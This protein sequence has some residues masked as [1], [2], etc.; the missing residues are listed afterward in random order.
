[1]Q[2]Q[3]DS[4]S[5]II[6]QRFKKNRFAL[7]GLVIAF[8]AAFVCVFSYLIIPDSS[9]NANQMC[10]QASL[11]PPGSK[12][13]YLKVKSELTSESSGI[14]KLFFG[15]DETN[16][17][18]PVVDYQLT[19]NIIHYKELGSEAFGW[20]TISALKVVNNG[21]DHSYLF[22][23]KYLLGADKFGRDVFSR[24][25]L[26][27]RVSF[28][29]GFIAVFISLFIGIVLGSLAGYYR[30]IIDSLITWMVNVI[31]SIPTLL[32]VVAITLALG[33]GFVQVFVAVGLT[34]WVEVAR[35]VRGQFFT[36][37]EAQF[38]EAGKSFGFNNARIIFKHILPNVLG[39]VIVIA[40]SNFA[41]AI[42]L[43]AGLSFLGMG[44][45]PPMPSW[46]MMIKENYG[47]IIMD[48]AYLAIIPGAAI[49]VLVMAFTLLG[50][51]LRDAFDVKQSKS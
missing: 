16:Q 6:W 19:N 3:T 49:A 15:N 21:K 41:S 25:I 29:V 32:L 43:E 46:G 33:K 28:S 9:Q 11:L 14:E 48:S 34:M 4:P 2:T 7:M 8:I 42:L 38:V 18:I 17:I 45:Q 35:L 20:Q 13:N 26:G 36:L 24:L 10:L 27:T 44:A 5:K 50:N 22:S 12:I 23:K 30:G 37:R 39:P 31:W 40:A 51:G 1:M 47:Y